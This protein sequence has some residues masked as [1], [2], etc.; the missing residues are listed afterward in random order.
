MNF[1]TKY[2]EK[3]E[4][5]IGI[6]SV[7]KFNYFDGKSSDFFKNKK[8]KIVYSESIPDDVTILKYKKIVYETEQKF[9]LYVENGD[10]EDVW[11]L[12]IYYQPEQLNELKFFVN[13]LNKQYK[14]N[15]QSK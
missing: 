13:Q 9:Y 3:L 6:F 10:S 2:I 12:T 5:K 1:K 11:F 8:F 15:N 7:V 14:K 4:E